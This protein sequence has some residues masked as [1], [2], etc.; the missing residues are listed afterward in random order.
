MS[1]LI[2]YAISSETNGMQGLYSFTLK[3]L[4]RVRKVESS[5]PKGRP[6]LTQHCKRFSTASTTAQV[7]MLLWSYDAEMDTANSL[8]ASA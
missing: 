7:S 2:S 3:L 4:P 6:N 1:L 8:H 5:N